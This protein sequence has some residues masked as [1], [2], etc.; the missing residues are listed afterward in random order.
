MQEVAVVGRDLAKNLFKVHGIAFDSAV[1]FHKQS[2]R[3]QI[4]EFFDGLQPCLAR[5][6]ACASAHHW[7]RALIGLGHEVRL[8]APANMKAY[9]KRG[10]TDAETIAEAVTRPTMRFVAV[11]TTAQQA[12]LMLLKTRDLLVRQ[13]TMLAYCATILVS[14]GA[15]ALKVLPGFR[16]L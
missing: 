2:P 6:E 3:A 1:V 7:A 13:R 12:V 14:A 8:M 5:I 11:K 4:P 16:R 10:K 15:R 9:V